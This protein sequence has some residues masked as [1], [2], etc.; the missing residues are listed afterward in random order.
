MRRRSIFLGA[1][2]KGY[3]HLGGGKELATMR[4]KVDRWMEGA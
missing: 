4:T 3:P 1:I 2:L